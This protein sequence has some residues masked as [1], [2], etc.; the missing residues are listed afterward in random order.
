M[1]GFMRLHENIQ[2]RRRKLKKNTILFVPWALCRIRTAAFQLFLETDQLIL[3]ALTFRVQVNQKFVGVCSLLLGLFHLANQAGHQGSPIL[4][5]L[6][7]PLERLQQHHQLG[8]VRVDVRV[9]HGQ[10]RHRR[11][12]FFRNGL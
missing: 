12:H 10:P 8:P 5:V 6:R 3:Q 1:F 9:Q 2:L 4:L 11:L 7:F